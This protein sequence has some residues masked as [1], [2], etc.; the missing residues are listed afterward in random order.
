MSPV[1][2][3]HGG[4]GRY[5]EADDRAG[6]LEGCEAAARE[7]WA[8]L[9]AGG[10]ALDAVQAAVMAL[11]DDPRFN[12]GSGSVLN[13]EGRVEMDAAIMDGSTVRAGAVAAV[14]TLR[15]PVAAAR[16]VLEEGRT[17]LRVGPAA[18]A[19]ARAQ[20]LEAVEPAAL[21]TPR[22][23]A[24]W[25]AAHETVGCVALDAQG[26]LAAATSTGGLFDKPPGRVGDSALIGCGTYADERGAVSCT[27]Q[28][29]AII[30]AALAMRV[31]SGLGADADPQ[32]VARQA[33]LWLAQRTGAEAGL[34]LLDH[35]GRSAVVHNAPYMAFCRIEGEGRM[36]RGL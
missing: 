17:V 1:L 36:S 14:T 20:G 10:S 29:E 2:L 19:F 27:G 18:E 6:A 7:G 4:A 3:V 5:P 32:A 25:Q 11:E 13:A 34:I 31:L 23:Q 22:Q 30:R 33:L 16:R 26:R 12:A 15:N 24:R 8:V 9:R 28:G 35:Q 21:I